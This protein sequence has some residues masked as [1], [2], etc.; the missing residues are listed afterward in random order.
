M[1]EPIAR[2]Y[3]LLI[4]Q[5]KKIRNITGCINIRCSAQW[6]YQHLVVKLEYFRQT[7][8]IPLLIMPWPMFN[9]IHHEES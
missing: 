6:L 2:N 7:K 9:K 8:T 1:S 3:S 4:I 5:P